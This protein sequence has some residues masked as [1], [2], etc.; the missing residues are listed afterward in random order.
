MSSAAEQQSFVLV[1]RLPDGNV[2]WVPLDAPQD[3]PVAPNAEYTLIERPSYEAPQTLVAERVGDDL[4]VEVNGNPVLVL[5]GFFVSAGTSFYPTTDIAGGAGPFSGPPLSP[6]SP[7]VAAASEGGQVVWSAAPVAGDG[8]G[9]HAGDTAGGSAL[10]WV[11]VGAGLLGV[12]ALAGGGGGSGGGGDEGSGNPGG[13]GGRDRTPP[14]ITS[15]ATA[16]PITENGGAGRAVYTATATDA[17]TVTFSIK[18]GGDSDA[19]GI[20]ATTGVV[21]LV[22]AANFEARSSYNFT[23]VARDAAGNTAEQTVSLAITNV[24]ESAPSITSST[25]AP[26]IA[27]NSGA[28]QVVYTV[29]ST[30]TGDVSSGATTY[31]LTGVDADFFDINS[32]TGAVTLTVN[33]DFES[34]SSYQFTV[35]AT[36]AANNRSEQAVSLGIQD[37]FGDGGEDTTRPTLTSTS[38]AD[39][40]ENVPVDANIVLTFSE[41][42]H[43]GVGHVHIRD[44]GDNRT[45]DVDDTTQV[46]IVGNRVT[47][48]LTDDL[49]PDGSYTVRIDS[50]A[51]VDTAGNP[52]AGLGG[53]DT[54]E[55]RTAGDENI[56][57]ASLEIGRSFAPSAVAGIEIAPATDDA[58]TSAAA[59]GSDP[60]E[61]SVGLGSDDRVGLAGTGASN[62]WP[63]FARADAAE[64]DAALLDAPSQIGA[65]DVVPALSNAMHLEI[66]PIVANSHDVL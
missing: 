5:D 9:A 46:T 25:T 16:S 38:P 4:V 6:S 23:V 35:V 1:R 10:A 66:V 12:A 45:I 22:D 30:D 2:E 7:V 59:I 3:V 40:T 42:V 52:F 61:G 13:S 65:L 31:G 11:G 47:I 18:P 57:T 51:F 24:D 28:G 14:Q 60:W 27:E 53:G 15:G 36:D 48:N 43:P 49:N 17:G 37:V 62:D 55:F 50:G 33:P 19:F 54:V 56:Q 34:K 20:D 63:A 21:T 29:T 39:D 8:D 58:A 64:A 26:T 32:S 41:T 44:G